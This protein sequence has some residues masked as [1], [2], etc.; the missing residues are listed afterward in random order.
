MYFETVINCLN[1]LFTLCGVHYAPSCVHSDNALSFLSREIK[2]FF[3]ERGIATSYCSVYHPTG[4]SQM[5][6]YNG[7]IWR[8]VRLALKSQNLP[9]ER[10]KSVLPSVSHSL[11]SLLRTTTN[12]SPHESYFH[13]HRKSCCGLSLP[14]WLTHPGPDLM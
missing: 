3:T 7:V 14:T 8:S 11:R 1:D 13:F 4:N 9:I 10:W 12:A 6:R 2:D 5:E